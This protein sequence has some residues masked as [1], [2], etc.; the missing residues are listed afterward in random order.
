M[1]YSLAEKV[2]GACLDRNDASCFHERSCSFVRGLKDAVDPTISVFDSPE[3]AI[4]KL[5]AMPR[6][7]KPRAKQFV[8]RCRGHLH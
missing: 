3:K 4:A 1:Q 5:D 6:A 2:L 8:D 7:L